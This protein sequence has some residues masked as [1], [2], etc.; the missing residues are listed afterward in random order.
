VP[1]GGQEAAARTGSRDEQ[2]IYDF[3]LTVVDV[4]VPTLFVGIVDI[5][6]ATIGIDGC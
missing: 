1:P 4:L 6:A 2:T 3:Q 5:L